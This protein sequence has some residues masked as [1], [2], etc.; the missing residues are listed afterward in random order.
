MPLAV[1][2]AK[3]LSKK[4]SRKCYRQIRS[5]PEQGRHYNTFEL[6]GAKKLIPPPPTQNNLRRFNT[7]NNFG[8]IHFRPL[9]G[10]LG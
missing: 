2:V 6:V 5:G 8:K 4:H 10:N 7:Q 3:T 1:L 9:L